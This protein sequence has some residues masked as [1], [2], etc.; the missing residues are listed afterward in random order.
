MNRLT[1][2]TVL[3]LISFAAPVL[4]A[5]PWTTEEIVLEVAFQAVLAIDWAQTH[6]I[7]DRP[8]KREHNPILGPYPSHRKADELILVASLSHILGTHYLSSKYRKWWI[9]AWIGV[10]LIA[11]NYNYK[12]HIRIV[13]HRF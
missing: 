12:N 6:E 10:E 1:L 8:D 2:A 13:N 3:F 11:V 9:A 5:D 4:A 7:V